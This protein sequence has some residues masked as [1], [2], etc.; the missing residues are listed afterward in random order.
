[1]ITLD[2][3][4]ARTIEQDGCL[5]WDGYLDSNGSPQANINYRRTMVRRLVYQLTHER[6]PGKNFVGVCCTTYGCVH[7]DHLVARSRSV[8]FLGKPRNLLARAKI[9]AGRRRSSKLPQEA[10]RPARSTPKR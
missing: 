9:A 1:M 4:Q 7:P 8:A 10:V 6:N 3:L 2:W 5:V